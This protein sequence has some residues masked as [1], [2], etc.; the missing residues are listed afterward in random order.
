[1]RLKYIICLGAGILF[2]AMYVIGY[3]TAAGWE[4]EVITY[5]HEVNAANAGSDDNVILKHG[6]KYI[7]E[8]Y[9]SE[10]EQ[11]STLEDTIPVELVGLTRNQVIEFI[12]ENPDYFGEND[13]IVRNVMLV[14]FSEN[15]IV[16]RKNVEIAEE[17]T[18]Y[19]F[20]IGD[21]E[22]K[23]YIFLIDNAV[24][25]YKED[26]TTVY[27]ET[28]IT[29]DELDETVAQELIMG[30]AVKNISELYRLLESYTT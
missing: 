17:T 4:S 18:E 3:N 10:T 24:I 23:Y 28:G 2:I 7:L 6:A 9:N 22:P 25:V 1:M 21:N 29:A 5:D 12:G 11:S 26:K 14:S 8:A 19:E 30:V 15:R 27:M 16:I 13:E 20:N